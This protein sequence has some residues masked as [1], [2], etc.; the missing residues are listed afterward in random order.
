M[1][2]RENKEIV[3]PIGQHKIKIK[4]WLT[5]RERRDIRSVLLENVQFAMKEGEENPVSDYKLSANSLNQ[6]QD[7]TLQTMI[8]DINGSTETIL[9]TVL[10]MKEKDYDFIISEIDKITN[11][12]IEAETKKK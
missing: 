5:A 11:D 10:D 8:I 7:K 9:D 2:E 6:M 1:S 12:K 4:T 3:T